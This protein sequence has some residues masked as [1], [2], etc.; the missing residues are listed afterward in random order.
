MP[1]PIMFEP[2]DTYVVLETNQ[3]E[4]FMSRLELAAKIKAI[5]LENPE[6]L[7]QDWQSLSDLEGEITKLIETGCELS[8]G[9]DRYL[10]W[11][12]V[13]LEK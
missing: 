12:V 4:Y 10:Q 8:L 3:P 1:D 7:Q 9:P 13:R 5:A 6:E 2:E 11:Y